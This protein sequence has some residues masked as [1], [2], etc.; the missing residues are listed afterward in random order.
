MWVIQVKE[1]EVD[2]ILLSKGNIYRDMKVC[3]DNYGS[4]A[5]ILKAVCKV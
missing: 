5:S 1:G 3:V 4:L 2:G